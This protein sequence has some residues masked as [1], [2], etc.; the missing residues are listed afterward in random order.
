MGNP[1]STPPKQGRTNAP[2][3]IA[4]WFLILACALECV[5]LAFLLL[6]S[7]TYTS[8]L[9]RKGEAVGAANMRE[10]F[11]FHHGAPSA[12]LILGILIVFAGFLLVAQF[13]G[14]I[15]HKNLLKLLIITVLAIQLVWIASLELTAFWYPDSESLMDGANALVTGRLDQFAPNYCQL[16]EN[17][18]IC[19]QRPPTV[20][21][22]YRYF[23][24][25]P[26][27][28]GPMM[29]YV[30]VAWIFGANNVIA[31][32]M[33]NAIAITGLVALLWRLGVLLGLNETGESV[34]AALV[35]TCVPLLTF[36][37][38][39]YPNAVGFT[40]TILGVVVIAQSFLAKRVWV[41]VLSLFGGFLICG[42]GIVFKSTFIIVLLAA[43]I[44]VILAILVNGQ[45]W[46][47]LVSLIGLICANG[48]T[49]LPLRLVQHLTHQ[50]FGKGMP[51]S[52]WLLLGLSQDNNA[53]PGWW[54]MQAIQTF[55]KARGNYALQSEMIREALSHRLR[56]MQNNPSYAWQFFNEKLASEWADPTFMTLLYSQ[57]GSSAH[58]FTGLP[59]WLLTG[60]N[61]HRIFSFENTMQSTV[62]MLGLIGIIA[63]LA[64]AIRALMSKS[65]A[66]H[67][68]VTMFVRAF[69]CASFLGGFICYVFWEA[70]GIYTLPFYILLLPLAAYG[71]QASLRA[72][73][74]LFHR[75]KR[76]GGQCS[77]MED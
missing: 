26:F 48:L 34:L 77:G 44:A 14:R 54:T 10:L 18:Q 30:F 17:A 27:Q 33:L 70:K 32:Q 56:Y 38:F 52:S 16:P 35:L 51:M 61:Y 64:M 72:I 2:A 21:I 8:E 1:A 63:T 62:Y 39:V 57:Q 60:E 13:V 12:G 67:A 31:F 37:A 45:W 69:M 23:S 73:T 20:P 58:H 29:W 40:I 4:Q 43:F 11:T 66:P 3:R 50:N 71:A 5:V 19:A 7:L 65:T 15:S 9:E 59:Q 42:I 6:L 25:Y 49:Q 55:D 74:M 41:S 68:D 53:S 22:A 36:A 76:I 46:R 24:L 47:G 28:T 75:Y